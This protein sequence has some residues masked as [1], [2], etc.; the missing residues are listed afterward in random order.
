MM[1]VMIGLGLL[2][3]MSVVALAF[4]FYN[5]IKDYNNIKAGRPLGK[6]HPDF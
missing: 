5:T 2:I 4:G 3:V 1:V 6:N